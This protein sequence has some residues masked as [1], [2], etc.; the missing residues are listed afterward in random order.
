MQNILGIPESALVVFSGVVAETS[1]SSVP[2]GSAV[3][4]TDCDFTVGSV[5]TRDGVENVYV[6]D[7]Y[8]LL[9]TAGN[10][11]D[12][13]V[14]GGVAWS[15]PNNLTLNTPGTYAS[16]SLQTP[17]T[18]YFNW[19]LGVVA[20]SIS[21]ST[22]TLAFD[23]SAGAGHAPAPAF[24]TWA[25][26][27]TKSVSSI[28]TNTSGRIIDSNGNIQ[29]VVT[30]GTTKSGTHP[31]WATAKGAFTTDGTVT[32]RNDGSG[33][34]IVAVGDTLVFVAAW[35]GAQ[36]ISSV[37]DSY[38]NKWTSDTTAT[39][40]GSENI[41]FWYTT[42]A[43]AIANAA[44]DFAL[45]VNFSRTGAVSLDQLFCSISGAGVALPGAGQGGA[46]PGNNPNLFGPGSFTTTQSAALL[47]ALYAHN[48]G[49]SVPSGF[50]Q[51]SGNWGAG[52]DNTALA[53]ENAAAGTYNPQATG[54]PSSTTSYA[55][56]VQPFALFP[57]GI[58]QSD[59]LEATAF[60]V[61]I[62]A[63]ATVLGVQLIVSGKQ[64]STA[65][66]VELVA[67]PLILNGA[68]QSVTFQLGLTDGSKTLGT[69]QGTWGQNWT[70]AQLESS[71]FGFSIQAQSPSWQTFDISG[72]QIKVYYSPPTVTQFDHVTSFAETDGTTLTLALDSGG[73]LWQEDAINNAGVLSPIFTAI[74]PNTFAVSVTQD[75]REFLAL[76][77][78]Q[79][80]TDMPRGYDGTNLDRLSQVGPAVAPQVTSIGSGYTVLTINQAAAVGMTGGAHGWQ[81]VWS[82]NAAVNNSGN[83]IS[84]QA[85]PG[86]LTDVMAAGVGATV[87]LAG[88]PSYHGLSPNGTYQITAVGTVATADYGAA[89]PYFSVLA[90]STNN[91]DS[92]I[93]SGAT[94]QLTQAT[95]TTSTPVPNL[96]PGNQMTVSGSSIAGYNNTWTVTNGLDTSG[97]PIGNTSQMT[98]TDTSLTSNVASYSYTLAAGA[99]PSVGEQ[100]TVTGTSNGGGI[101]NVSNAI[102]ASV[103]P[104]GLTGGSFSVAIIAS[105]VLPGAE[106]GNAIVAGTVFTFDPQSI[107][108]DATGG[109]IAISGGLGAGTRGC[110]Q[111]F[112]TRNGLLTAPS[113]QAI[114]TLGSSS[115]KLTV[116][117]LAI[118]PPDVIARVL[119]FTGANGATQTGGG[120]FYFWLP[121]PVQVL[122]TSTGQLQTYDATII[123]DNT[124]TQVTLNLTDAVLLAGS[125]ISSQG[126]NNFA[127]IELGSST[128]LIAYASRLFA[129]G[130]Q[131]K[132]QNLLNFSFDGGLGQ[133]VGSTVTT[134][135][136]GW[137][138]DPNNG[139]GGS[140]STSP[141]FGNA[142]LI[143]NSSG[144]TQALYGMITQGAYKDQLNVPIVQ[145]ATT[146]SVRVTASGSGA[147]GNLNVDFY[148]PSTAQIWGK[149]SIPISSLSSTMKIFSGALLTSAF[150]TVPSDLLIRIY[151]STMPD[152][153]SITI[154]RI[155]PF[156]TASPVLST[157][158]RASYFDNFEAFDQVTGN[159]GVGAQN[160]Q[161]VTNAFSL[162][163]NLYAVKTHSFYS[164]TDNG[165]TEPSGWT[166]REVSNKVGTPSIH[167]VDVGE[168]WA[169][170]AGQ[171][172]LYIFTG[173]D[174]VK[175]SPEIDPI[176]AQINWQYGHT[177]WLRNDTN[178]RKIFIGVPMKTP[179]QWMPNFPANSN[180]TQPNVVL[181]CNYK[182]LMTSSMLASEGP[183]RQ[184][185]LGDLKTFS[186]G[187]KWSA[188]SIEACYADFIV[189]ADTTTPLFFCSDAGP[190]I[191]QQI[192]GN[193]SDDGAAMLCQYVTYPFPQT[194]DAQAM[195]MGLHE[196]IAEYS[197]FQLRGS[198]NFVPKI[199]PDT[200]NSPD[201]ETQY[202][203]ALSDPIPGGDVEIPWNTVGCR[204]FIGAQVLEAGEWFELSRIVLATRQNVWASVRG[205]N[206]GAE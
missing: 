112:L 146:Y 69:P 26:S 14:N 70:N 203:V 197:G 161:P 185:F 71:L 82:Q 110:V 188:W 17:T 2:V 68:S 53:F 162:F 106:T 178:N 190:K 183:V 13:A 72:V 11:A 15:S 142:Y 83:V 170:I 24:P 8:D 42:A 181:M 7:G 166:V 18:E 6:Y 88:L 135:P 168:G 62:P 49:V 140:L 36:T 41:Q 58:S 61:T 111:M 196:L 131:N 177:L 10:G 85:P 46:L 200:L 22:G 45:T 21:S 47:N 125:S 152:G 153:A 157:Q 27:S 16:V 19:Q 55:S 186:L 32:W 126:S 33:T 92:N 93:P 195:Q 31:T 89:T 63:G 144:S 129:W 137:T 172:G 182:E 138:V 119:A 159:L 155:E 156:P 78:L 91:T 154:D 95:L 118:G 87:V 99:Q 102:I 175:I 80:G 5:I 167:G 84:I 12:V 116:T 128:G 136:L 38:G 180:P 160:Q 114:F 29:T 148:S 169:L 151:A 174:P 193:Y 94:Y 35:T 64:S 77:D 113:P 163:D 173:G 201:A 101:F 130:E 132:I 86:S 120:G 108:G 56:A 205:I 121:E 143:S 4:C 37:T 127:Q 90:T 133:A 179:N 115:L 100:V 184:T 199:Y 164:T 60:A 52:A 76:S 194:R 103:S 25:Q 123:N 59:L 139:S 65:T 39:G 158:L 40:V 34:N 165:V 23:G 57:S 145:A 124:T 66:G 48:T 189:R 117:G 147:S 30:A 3:I 107:I 9:L 75:D 122:D 28:V 204:F 149:Y 109:A 20:L 74:E 206:F 198:G 67:T 105:D 81:I 134:Y 192:S 44:T 73:V 150:G 79:N 104:V 176:W 98:V 171:S 191:Y 141:L 1:P 187:R 51:V 43:K 50:A 97:K 96:Y 54:N 202:P